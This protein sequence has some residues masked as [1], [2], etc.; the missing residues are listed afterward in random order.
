M[1]AR[2]YR[3]T[4]RLY[5]QVAG[6]LQAMG[7]STAVGGNPTTLGLVP[8]GLT[9]TNESMK[10]SSIG[11]WRSCRLRTWVPGSSSRT[12]RQASEARFSA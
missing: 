7:V 3:T 5:G 10:A 6:A 8:V 12:E 9:K 11:P 1:T 2:L 4:Q